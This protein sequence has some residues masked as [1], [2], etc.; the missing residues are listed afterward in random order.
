MCRSVTLANSWQFLSLWTLQRCWVG[1][2]TLKSWIQTRHQL[3]QRLGLSPAW[4]G[5]A[6][7]PVQTALCVVTMSPRG[8][9]KCGVFTGSMSKDITSSVALVLLLFVG[10]ESVFSHI[11]LHLTCLQLFYLLECDVETACGLCNRLE[12]LPDC[13]NKHQI[14]ANHGSSAIHPSQFVWLSRL[15]AW[16]GWRSKANSEP[17][18]LLFFL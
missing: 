9:H 1:F 12:N 5:A 6:A 8:F 16:P 18:Q 7:L 13:P 14:I 15:L 2:V 17:K 11:Q 4:P 10:S 3:V